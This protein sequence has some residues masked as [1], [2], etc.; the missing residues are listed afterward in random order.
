M[1]ILRRTG[2]G[3]VCPQGLA[4]SAAE[5]NPAPGGVATEVTNGIRT[6]SCWKLGQEEMFFRTQVFCVWGNSMNKQTKVLQGR[7]SRHVVIPEISLSFK[8]WRSRG[9]AFPHKGWGTQV[10]S[11]EL[12]RATM[13]GQA[14]QRR[15]VLLGNSIYIS[16][17]DR[18]RKHQINTKVVTSRELAP[19]ATLRV[20]WSGSRR[21]ALCGLSLKATETIGSCW[22]P[23][24]AETSSGFS[25]HSTLRALSKSRV[26][27]H[28]APEYHRAPAATPHH[29]HLQGFVSIPSIALQRHNSLTMAC[30]HWTPKPE[31]KNRE[32]T[33]GEIHPVSTFSSSVSVWFYPQHQDFRLQFRCWAT[34]LTFTADHGYT[35]PVIC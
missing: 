11:L 26:T 32:V 21:G 7:E 24:A 30:T 28:K 14:Q 12:G 34:V 17:P 5:W 6:G 23:S 27:L 2:R 35:H 4:L 25:W 22:Q 10:A 8:M 13:T 31:R 19:P 16:N 3:A 20:V 15:P 9:G 33:P 18:P 29:A 1:R